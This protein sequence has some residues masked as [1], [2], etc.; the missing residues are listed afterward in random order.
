MT[1]ELTE[2][3]KSFAK[4]VGCEVM[5]GELK[6]V[7]LGLYFPEV[8]T[9]KGNI[10]CNG[11]NVF[12]PH[13]NKVYVYQYNLVRIVNKKESTPAEIV[14]HCMAWLTTTNR[15]KDICELLIEYCEI[16]GFDIDYDFNFNA[17]KSMAND[18]LRQGSN[19]PELDKAYNGNI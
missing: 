13:S 6:G 5:V 19:E 9:S 3:E 17:L 14:F 15:K 18:K 10:R 12:F 4:N 2:V 7:N 16:Q 11:V 8:K 1:Y